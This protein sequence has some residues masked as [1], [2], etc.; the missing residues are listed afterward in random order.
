MK[1]GKALLIVDV[2]NDFCP[3]GA[4]AVPE[5]DH[6]V[7]VLNSYISAF[8]GKNLPILASR[9]WH[10]KRSKH[11]QAFGG[12][13]PKHCVQN[14]TGAKFHPKLKLPKNTIIL[15]KGMDPEEDSY[16]AFQAAD[17]NGT[18]LQ[19]VL[20]ILGVDT[21]FIGG[22]ATDYC[23]KQSVLDALKYSFHVSVLMDA[24]KGINL[25][26][27]D[28]D[29]ALRNMVMRGAR[30]MAFERLLKTWS[31]QIPVHCDHIG[32]FTKNA[33][34]LENFYTGILEFKKEKEEVLPKSLM[35]KVLGVPS[36]S[37]LLRLASGN[38]KLELF[39]P[40]MIHRGKKIDNSV[41]YNHWGYHVGDRERF[42]RKLARRGV[43][44]LEAQRG[45]HKVYF[46]MDPD[47][48]RIEI[49]D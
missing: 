1:L 28:S 10:P 20:R 13:W 37:K 3:G 17:S 12:L 22:L 11:F 44:V 9:D 38:M 33:K 48:N 27:K 6:V 31:S 16:S 15:S 4:L 2:Q 49:R 42:V 45:D 29:I 7:P 35:Q 32:I 43:N 8:L 41:G 21:L 24:I 46:L 19:D 14:T 5:G 26:P 30:K 36:D 40:N 34:R 47:G 25:K 39:Q 23:V 18:V